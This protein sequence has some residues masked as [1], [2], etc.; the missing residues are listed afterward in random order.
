M[1]INEINYIIAITKYY[2]HAPNSHKIQTAIKPTANEKK[3]KVIST[4][5]TIIQL[6]GY[7]YI[8]Q[9]IFYVFP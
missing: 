2:A 4:K 3:I 6:V 8:A 5:G 7:D 1:L 9:N